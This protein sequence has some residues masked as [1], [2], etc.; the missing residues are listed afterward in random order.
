MEQTWSKTYS[1][2]Q[3]TTC[4]TVQLPWR[5]RRRVSAR[6]AS[7]FQEQLASLLSLPQ[8]KFRPFW[9]ASTAAIKHTQQQRKIRSMLSTKVGIVTAAGLFSILSFPKF[10]GLVRLRDYRHDRPTP[11][12]SEAHP[13]DL[14]AQVSYNGHRFQFDDG[15]NISWLNHIR[16]GNWLGSGKFSDTFAAIF[17]QPMDK[18]YIIKF[19]GSYKLDNSFADT[20]AHAVDVVARLS[21]HP[22]IPQTLY[23]A[24]N[25]SNPFR[26]GQFALPTGT[27][28]R[29]NSTGSEELHTERLHRSPHVSV[30]VS[31]RVRQTHKH[32]S[33]SR[34]DVPSEQVRCFWR[35]FFETLDYAHS[36]KV[37]MTDT[38]LWNVMLQDGEMKFFDWNM[39]MIY[40]TS[41]DRHE[42]HAMNTTKPYVT[43]SQ[44]K[45]R[46]CNAVHHYDV[47]RLSKR[48]DE[49]LAADKRKGQRDGS[50]LVSRG[51]RDYLKD[52]SDVMA[53]EN[54]PTMRWLLDH[55]NYFLAE[56]SDSCTLKW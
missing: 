32:L 12:P 44:G 25:I 14:A 10:S 18:E 23:F 49:F 35:R 3:H 4:S 53:A 28:D 6:T 38:K 42:R 20:A 17:D 30:I 52:L 54:P 9:S 5:G 2:V 19:S 27:V 48:I 13:A 40:E 8:Q 47:H 37:I 36:K 1:T 21:P 16:L 55:H 34:L 26:T 33:H 11:L 22:N 31:E 29:H 50:N 45:S 15:E 7:T 51:D 56:D 43:C 41:E 46:N 39:A 24:R